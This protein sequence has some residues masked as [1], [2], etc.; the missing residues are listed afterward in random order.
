MS[1]GHVL[2]GLSQLFFLLF[3]L[4]LGIIIFLN[5]FVILVFKDCYCLFLLILCNNS[6]INFHIFLS[7]SVLEQIHELYL[8]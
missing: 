2:F 8:I 7:Y 6:F 1:V 4:L 5:F 3:F